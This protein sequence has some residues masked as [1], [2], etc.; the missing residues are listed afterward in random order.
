L[1]LTLGAVTLPP[2]ITT[3]VR[4]HEHGIYTFAL[5]DMAQIELVLSALRAANIKVMD[6]QLKEADLE[7]VFLSLVGQSNAGFANA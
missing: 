1:R 4:H 6:M 3:L 7:D 5:N 2:A